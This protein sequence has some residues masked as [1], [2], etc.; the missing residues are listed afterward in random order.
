MQVTFGKDA[1]EEVEM[2]EVT[3]PEESQPEP[4]KEV[5]AEP[6]PEVVETPVVKEEPKPAE[7]KGSKKK[8]G[9]NNKQAAEAPPANTPT[10]ST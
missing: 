8:K 1:T 5:K 2:A 3:A 6:V 10:Q 4:V 7:S 9:K